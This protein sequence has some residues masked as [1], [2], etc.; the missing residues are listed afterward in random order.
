MSVS[1]DRFSEELIVVNPED[2]NRV[3][4]VKLNTKVI[5]KKCT[6]KAGTFSI[7]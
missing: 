7:D 1:V 2:S 6:R 5:P 4:L 3:K